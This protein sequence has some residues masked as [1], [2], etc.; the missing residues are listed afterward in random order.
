MN[1]NIGLAKEA[2]LF[3]PHQ[4]SLYRCINRLFQKCIKEKFSLISRDLIEIN[5]TLYEYGNKKIEAATA[6]EDI[7][8][9]WNAP[10]FIGKMLNYPYESAEEIYSFSIKAIE[11]EIAKKSRTFDHNTHPYLWTANGDH[12]IQFDKETCTYNHY[13]AFKLNEL[14]TLDFFSP[15]CI[16]ID[17]KELE[18]DQ[19]AVIEEY[20]YEEAYAIYEK[21]EESVSPLYNFSN[22]VIELI[23][24]FTQVIILKK[25]VQK[26]TI[27][28]S[29]ASL[30]P[31]IGRSLLI[32]AD[33]AGSSQIIDALVHESI[34]S[35]L[36]MID[37]IKKW[38]PANAIINKVGP[39][40]PSP[41]TGRLLN[42]GNFCQAIFVWYGLF[43]FWQFALSNHLYDQ[44]YGEK[45]IATIEKGFE[46]VEIDLMNKKFQLQLNDEVLETVE[47]VKAAVPLYSTQW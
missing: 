20:N 24:N 31:Y 23:T 39:V 12:F 8:G 25:Q 26:E 34:H 35:M 32:N 29:S 1:L 33:R 41:W 15:N 2:L 28:F 37:A 9:V 45:R 47:A 36:Y 19:S 10:E 46:K 16:R 38:M 42:P 4:A 3:Q 17:S 14:I 7:P 40:I 5:E 44:G 30:F 11:A 21:L 6:I 18:E 13:N 43:N 22:S 27:L